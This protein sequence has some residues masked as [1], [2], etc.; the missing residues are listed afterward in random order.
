M[1]PRSAGAA[2]GPDRLHSVK[3][4]NT[5][6]F[7]LVLVGCAGSTARKDAV[8]PTEDETAHSAP[9]ALKQGRAHHGGER[10]HGEADPAI[11]Q[12]LAE[13]ERNPEL[14]LLL[15]G[16]TDARDAGQDPVERGLHRA[17]KLRERLLRAAGG[18]I[19]PSRIGVASPEEVGP[20]LPRPTSARDARRRVEFYF[21]VPDDRPLSEHFGR[22]LVIAADP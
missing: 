19:E 6:L 17:G 22:P 8:P 20:V 10:P 2:V 5:L 1:K 15:I 11:E 9:P 14:R 18:R 7:A 21:Y 3:L 16:R 12:A 4:R 13:L